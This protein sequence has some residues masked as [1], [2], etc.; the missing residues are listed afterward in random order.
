M[1]APEGFVLVGW[2]RRNVTYRGVDGRTEG[3]RILSERKVYEDDVPLYAP[4]ES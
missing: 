1:N 3:E 2:A 4:V